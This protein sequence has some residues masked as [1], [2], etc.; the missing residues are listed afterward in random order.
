MLAQGQAEGRS[1]EMGR[2]SELNR[3]VV[4]DRSYPKQDPSE[5]Q[6][7]QASQTGAV[8]ERIR[9]T[10]SFH[11]MHPQCPGYLAPE[12]YYGSPAV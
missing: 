1:T 3:S 7:L 2:V 11:S 6:V 8:A 9:F 5:L 12:D 10:R 4:A